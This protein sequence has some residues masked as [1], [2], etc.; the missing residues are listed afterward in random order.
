MKPSKWAFYEWH[1]S[2]SVILV[3]FIKRIL[4]IGLVAIVASA[5]TTIQAQVPKP[6]PKPDKPKKERPEKGKWDKEN[7]KKRLK[8]AFEK[9]SKRH[10]DAKKRGH[11]VHDRK[12]G[13]HKGGSF[14]KLVRDDA[15]IKELKEAFAA[16]AKKGHKG[17]D[18]KAW[19]DASDE[20]KKALREKMAAGR[21]EWY[22]KMKTHH[23]EVGK[24]IKEI[25]AEFKN[26]RDKVIDGNDPGE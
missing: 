19:K 12:K 22:E 13:N 20:E 17:F 14:G 15:K 8:A 7:M 26:N 5:L 11:K 4:K 3:M 23:K 24:R 21:K 6:A 10:K 9:R 16:A 25:R 2:C 18:R 1:D